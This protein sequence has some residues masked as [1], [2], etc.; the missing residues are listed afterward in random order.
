[1]KKFSPHIFAFILV[2]FISVTFVS[3]QRGGETVSGGSGSIPNPFNCGGAGGNCNLFMFVN[4]IVDRVLLPIGGI[5]VVLAFIYSGF[6]FVMAQG[7]DG[8]LKTAKAALTY[9]AIGAAILLGAKVL[10]TV[11][12]NTVN[13]LRA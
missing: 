12:E 5:L 6:K 1:M 8:E 2:F 13:S 7:N 4:T 9:T 3:A 11:I 10:T